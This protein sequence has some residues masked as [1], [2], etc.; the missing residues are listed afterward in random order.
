MKCYLKNYTS[1]WI[2]NLKERKKVWARFKDNVKVTDLVEMG[3]LSSFNCGGKYLLCV[4]DVFTKYACVK[5]LT[6]KTTKTVLHNF[7]E[8]VKQV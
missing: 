1:Q 2:K 8:I 5:F 4:T 7:I 3:S 6:N